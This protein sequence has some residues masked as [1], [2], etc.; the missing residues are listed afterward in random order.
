MKILLKGGRVLDPANHHDAVADVLIEDGV[1]A[2]VGKNLDGKADE[3][4]ALTP[5]HWVTPGLVDL[6][7]H[8][9][10]P[11]RPD[12]ET[13]ESGAAAAIAGGFTT[14]CLMPNTDPPI[15]DLPTLE[16]VNQAALK[17]P[18]RIHAVPAATKALKG[19]EIT[20]M[21]S[22]HANGAVGFTDDGRCIMN[23]NVMRLALEYSSML[24]VPIMCHA[25]DY[26][27]AGHGCMN[28]GYY[29]TLLGLPGSP[30]TAESVIVAR[31]I[32]LARQTGGHLHI[33]HIS[34]R[35]AVE[36]VRKAKAEG[37]RVT[38]EVTPHH[39]T[40]TDALVQ[41]YDPDYKMCPPLR[42]EADRQAVLNGLLDG[43]IDAIATDHAPH[44]QDEKAFTFDQAPNGVVGLETA[45]GVILTHLV[46][47]GILQPL[48]MIRR[49]T[50]APAEVAHLE[51]GTLTPGRPADIT[52][53]DPNLGWTVDP[54]KFKSK[55]RNSCF[56]GMALQ[57]KAV[58]VFAQG[59]CL[60]NELG[61][62]QP[63]P[64]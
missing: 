1:I 51:A 21:K 18:I 46:H 6:H 3:M 53:I 40:L 22:M 50:C 28:E 39:L 19:E 7:V 11:G 26:T 42:T 43:T 62:R 5:D 30:N 60:M 59:V 9:R 37:V 20:E 38:A 2:A 64:V 33:C 61:A 34:T 35:E 10:D 54:S 56:K 15:D 29:S 58:A 24:N 47:P 49:M 41:T 13:T 52:V 63:Q 55:S 31:D 17:T 23:A 4:I 57:G 8:F 36:L 16:Y 27:L 45:V 12:K 44:T 32:E 48:E 14:V 25:E